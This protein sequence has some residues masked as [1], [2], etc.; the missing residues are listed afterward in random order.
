MGSRFSWVCS[1]VVLVFCLFLGAALYHLFLLG[2][3]LELEIWAWIGI[4]LLVL[5]IIITTDITSSTTAM[6]PPYFLLTVPYLPSWP[7]HNA[8][9]LIS[10]VTSSSSP[11]YML[12]PQ[13]SNLYPS[14][15]S[16]HW[17]TVHLRCPQAANYFYVSCPIPGIPIKFFHTFITPLRSRIVDHFHF[18][19]IPICTEASKK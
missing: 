8:S 13:L 7:Y 15:V 1:V 2:L 12:R 16:M 6:K 17:L 4:L 5:L 18:V 3:G 19:P 10:V 14:H 9:A 11:L